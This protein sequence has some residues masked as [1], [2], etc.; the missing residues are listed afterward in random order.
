MIMSET[1]AASNNE[2][3]PYIC[4]GIPSVFGVDF[5]RS[6]NSSDLFKSTTKFFPYNIYTLEKDKVVD[7]YVVEV[8]LAGYKKSDIKINVEKDI[9]AIEVNKSDK[10]DKSINYLR[11]GI[12]YKSAKLELQIVDI[13]IKKIHCSFEDGLL[14]LELPVLKPK[15][16]VTEIKIG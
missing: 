7:K 12:S 14:K 6:I 2:F 4:D 3:I 9:L 1:F 8:A 5:I 10:V 15:K 11:K 16:E 13:D